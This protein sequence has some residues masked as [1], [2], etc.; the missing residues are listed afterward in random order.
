MESQHTH[1]S[2]IGSSGEHAE[3]AESFAAFEQ[4]VLERFVGRGFDK[5]VL[6]FGCGVGNLT[7]LLVESFPVVHGYDPSTDRT[8]LARDRA[9]KAVF[10]EDVDALPEAHYGAIVLANVLHH[11]PPESRLGLLRTL[12]GKCAK[13]GHI[14]VFEPNPYNPITRR[15]VAPHP[16]GENPAL[17]RSS[18][19]RHL[20]R[21]AG[22]HGVKREYLVFFPRLLAKLRPLERR[23]TWLPLGAEA[24]LWGRKR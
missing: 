17:L 23:L 14:V 11:V 21:R 7:R 19:V 12:H 16:P 4:K 9:P 13:G 15:A 20:L 6:D 22:F 8:K 18:E 3:A 24:C 10:F 5:P 2:G 1:S